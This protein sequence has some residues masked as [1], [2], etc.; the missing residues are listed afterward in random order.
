MKRP[1]I[2]FLRVGID[3]GIANTIAL[4]TGELLSTPDTSR[5]ER[6]KSRAQ[7]VL[8][9]R[10]RG[11]NRYRK[12]RQRLSRITSKIARVRSDWRHKSTLSITQRFG[13]VVLEDLRIP[14]MVKTNRGL[15]RSIH[16]QG[17]GAF[18]RV[19]TY[20]LEERGG[21]LIKI[22][23][24][25]TSQEC[26]ACG[27]IDRASRESQASFTCRHCGS[28]IHADTNA[29]I[30]ILRRSTASMRAEGGGYAPDE[31]RTINLAA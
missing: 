6:R 1:P 8:S 21:T 22:N 30:N 15:S 11:S 27:V 2:P 13:T 23:P 9:R 5:L 31:T 17:W 29:A 4:S 7:R 14:N 20:K 28:A 18:E 24:A 19:L 25:F 16:E 26:S 10:K 12:Q 3:R